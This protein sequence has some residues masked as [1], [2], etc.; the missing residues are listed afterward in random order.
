MFFFC[1]IYSTFRQAPEDDNEPAMVDATKQLDQYGF[2]VKYV[3]LS[4]AFY[5]KL[6]VQ[7]R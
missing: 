2:F 4:Q 6:H 5:D 3:S 1:V 7:K